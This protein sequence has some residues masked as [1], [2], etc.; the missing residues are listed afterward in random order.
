MKKIDLSIIIA[1][2]NTKE[3]LK[4]CLESIEKNSRG[5]GLEVVVVDNNSEDSSVDYLKS[6]KNIVTVFN[7]KNLGFAK[8]NNQGIKKAK[9][10]F[11]LLLNSDTIVKKGSLKTMVDYLKKNSDVAGVSPLVLNPDGS[12]QIDRYMKSPNIWHFLLYHNIL[13][14]PVLMATPLKNLVVNGVGETPFE[15]DQLSGAALMSRKEIFEKV[16][17]LDEDYSFL[18]EDIDWSY[19]VKKNNLGKLVV[20]PQAEILHIGGASWKKWLEKDRFDFYQHHFNS[21]LL[22]VRKHL[23]EKLLVFKMALKLSFLSNAFFHL[24]LFQWEKGRVQLKLAL[25]C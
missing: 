24:L 4:N 16:G 7:K 5:L 19:R 22:F 12:K 6:L 8:A 9:G 2:W 14:R 17:G 3:L 21:L 18:F 13:I 11:V 25:R 15:I 23:P 20:L 1:S 10:G